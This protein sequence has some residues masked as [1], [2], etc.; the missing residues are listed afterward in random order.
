MS[1]RPRQLDFSKCPR[2]KNRLEKAESFSG[3][4]SEFWLECS[5]A[6]CNT[7]VN[8][9]IP[10]EHQEAL[11]RDSHTIIGNFGGY[12][13]GKTLTSREEVMKHMFITDNANVAVGAKVAAQYEQTIKRELENDIPKG[14]VERWSVQKSYVDLLNNS[15]LMW[16]SFDDAGKLRSLN[17]SMFVMVEGSEISTEVFTQ[18]KTRSRNIATNVYQKDEYGQIEL[19]EEGRPIVLHDWRKGIVE[20]NPDSGYIRTDILL[21]SDKINQ[22]GNTEEEHYEQVESEKDKNIS[23]YVTATSANIYLPPDYEELQSKNKP[24]WWVRRYLKG[25]F[26]FSEGLVYP[27]FMENVVDPFPIPQEWRRIVA[28]DYGLSD[29]ASFVAGAVDPLAGIIYLYRNEITTNMDIQGLAKMYHRFTEDIPEGGLAF[30]PIIDPK[31]GVKRDYNKKSLI[32]LFLEEGVYFE[33]GAI[34]VDARV[35]RTNAYLQSGTVKIFST[36]SELIEEAREYKFPPKSL[37]GSANRNMHKPMDKNNH[38]IN[39]MEWILMKLPSNPRTLVHGMYNSEGTGY[40]EY[41]Q[42][43]QGQPSPETLW[44]LN[45]SNPWEED[46]FQTPSFDWNNL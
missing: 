1:R 4:T 3:M 15:R 24:D 37:D 27:G 9:Y 23:S 43:L 8:T 39:P 12:G 25:S 38:S 44:Q 28:F 26:Q 34:S 2:C 40:D 35:M 10:Q 46:A 33:P 19:N 14:L 31:S 21:Y 32:E 29:K 5:N 45:D 41:Q 18:L 11:H 30:P 6:K 36:C 17:L 42:K 7:F 13:S 16:R 22:F 20:S